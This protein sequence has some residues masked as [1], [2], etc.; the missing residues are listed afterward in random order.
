MI[1]ED[2]ELT[3]EMIEAGADVLRERMSD[4]FSFESPDARWIAKA[5]FAAMIRARRES[6]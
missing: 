6:P 2:E 3:P 1:D 4:V 5:V